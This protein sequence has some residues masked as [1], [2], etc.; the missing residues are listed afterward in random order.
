MNYKVH[1][2]PKIN[3]V[4]F[5]RSLK[6]MKDGVNI[7]PISIYVLQLFVLLQLQYANKVFDDVHEDQHN[8]VVNQ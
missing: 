3:F 7:F 6:I 1:L 8:Y 4:L 5:E 2:T